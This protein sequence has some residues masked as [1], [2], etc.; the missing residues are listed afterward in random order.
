MNIELLEEE[1][2]EYQNVLIAPSKGNIS[3]NIDPSSIN[4][5]F[6]VR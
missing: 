6:N 4:Y 2:V 5:F 3:R 1:Y